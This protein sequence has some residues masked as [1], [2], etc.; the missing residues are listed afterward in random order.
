MDASRVRR[1]TR[2]I[3]DL[4]STKKLPKALITNSFKT[5]TFLALEKA[6]ILHEFDEVITGGDVKNGKPDPEGYLL[7]AQK[8]GQNPKKCLIFEDSVPGVR[9]ALASGA[10]V[11]AVTDDVEAM[12]KAVPEV[13]LVVP[14]LLGVSWETIIGLE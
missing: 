4:I 7:A 8:L 11:I 12:Q 5:F 6:N 1:G 2:E 14:S 10:K 13:D 3:L 9:A